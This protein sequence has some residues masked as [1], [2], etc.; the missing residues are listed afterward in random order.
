MQDRDFVIKK[1]KKAIEKDQNVLLAY[2]FGSFAREY[3]TPLSD[4]DI[5][6]LLKENSLIH[7]ANTWSTIATALG[8]SEDKI[9]LLDLSKAPLS[10]KHKVIKEGIKLV[11]REDFQEKIVE[12]IVNRYPETSY[13][14]NETYEEMIKNLD[15]KIDKETIQSR[16]SE[17]LRCIATLEEEILNKPVE[18]VIK[19]RLH[20]IAMERCVHVV[21]EAMLDICRHIVSVKKLG[22]PTTYKD[23]VKLVADNDLIPQSMASQMEEYVVLRNIL[24][25]RYLQLDYEALYQ[26]AG[27]LVATVKTFVEHINSL[28]M[29]EEIR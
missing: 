29:Q 15:C 1:I 21:I 14:M 10:L 11:D 20:R 17:I 3:T 19:S 6:V 18:M 24:V 16:M 27:K 22:L 28:V 5:A 13:L 25:H 23:L 26:E 7:F 4:I 8:M 2:L 12:E 9:D